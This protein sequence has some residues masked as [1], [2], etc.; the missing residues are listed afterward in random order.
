MSDPG[1]LSS[2]LV[3]AIAGE[4][5]L[6]R[7]AL[8]EEREGERWLR[9]SAAAEERGLADLAEQARAR[10]QRHARMAALLVQRAQEMQLEVERLRELAQPSRSF[11]RAPPSATVEAEFAALEVEAELQRLR[12]QLWSGRAASEPPLSENE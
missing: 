9:R 2:A 4:H 10:A 6:R 3:D 1:A 7:Q 5:R 11:G 12:Q 8:R